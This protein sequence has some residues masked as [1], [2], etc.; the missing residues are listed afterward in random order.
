MGAP[1]DPL[2]VSWW[3]MAHRY[4]AHRRV[5]VLVHGF[6]AGAALW[7]PRDLDS[8]RKTPLVA[9]VPKML[10]PSIVTLLGMVALA[11]APVL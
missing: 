11:V 7:P 5:V 4:R 10:F 9:A 8:A 2:G 1:N 6:P 3:V